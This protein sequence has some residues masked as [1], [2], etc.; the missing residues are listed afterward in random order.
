MSHTLN[1]SKF[2]CDNHRLE[3]IPS[4]KYLGMDIHHKITRI[5]ELEKGLEEVGNHFLVLKI[6]IKKLNYGYGKENFIF[7]MLVILVIGYGCK[8]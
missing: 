6:I 4:Y 2:V 3:E 8:A 5:V 7:Y 1:L